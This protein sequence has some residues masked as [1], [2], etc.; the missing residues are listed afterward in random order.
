MKALKITISGSYRSVEKYVDFSNIEGVIPFNRED[1]AEMHIRGRYARMWIMD[2]ERF[3][4]R[5]QS[6]REVYIDKMDE[7]EHDF[8]FV[9]KDIREMTQAELQDLAT[10]KDL[11]EIPLY[12]I[13]GE[14]HART[15][16]YAAYSNQILKQEVKY[17]AE[18]FNLMKQPPIIVADQ[19]WRMDSTKKLT[20]DEIM[21]AEKDMDAPTVGTKMS[22]A[23]LEQIATNQGISFKGNWSD[24]KLYK[25][26]YG[27]VAKNAAA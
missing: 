16:A 11:R 1:I 13:S 4:D 20:N 26:I 25:A 19:A 27:G 14:R 23:E 17:R 6:V 15:V 2:N 5:L 8:S 12:K 24:D 18:G 22:R 9:G 21:D 7:A 3:K 10:A